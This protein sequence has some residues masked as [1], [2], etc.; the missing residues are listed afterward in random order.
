MAEELK[1]GYVFL[2]RHGLYKDLTGSLNVFGIEGAT[3]LRTQMDKFR[4]DHLDINL[5]ESVMV[6]GDLP[7]HKETA[8]ILNELWKLPVITLGSL[9][10]GIDAYPKPPEQVAE[11]LLPLVAQYR[12]LI[13]VASSEHTK[14]FEFIHEKGKEVPSANY[15]EANVMGPG[16]EYWVITKDEIRLNT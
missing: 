8:A 16:G 5:N 12:N 11:S 15:A 4:A 9:A 3:N 7:R 14:H 10:Y 1:N 6:Q 2:V 13:L